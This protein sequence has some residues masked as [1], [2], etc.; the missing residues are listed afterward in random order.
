MR[1]FRLLALLVFAAAALLVSAAAAAT[2]PSTIPLPNGWAPEGIASG[3]GNTLYVGSLKNGAVWAGSA[4][5]GEGKVR[6]QGRSG[7]SATGL[8]AD[9]RE[10]LFVAGALTGQGYV[11]NARTGRD[12]AVYTFTAKNTGFINDVVVTRRAA[13][14]TDSINPRLYVVPIA[15][16]GQLGPKRS[17]PLTGA[18]KYTKG[19]NVNGI[20]ATPDGKTLFLVQTNTGRLFTAD[21]ATGVTRE[22]D[23]G[24]ETLKNGDG[25]VFDDR[26]LWVALNRSNRVAVVRLAANLR[27]GQVGEP[28]TNPDFDVPSTLAAV[29]D[30]LYAVNARF[31]TPPRKTTKYDIVRVGE[32]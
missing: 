6:V 7:R 17:L 22:I 19:F 30:R 29:G 3:S 25:M 31:N 21:A 2:F 1:R 14:F 16:D 11:Y 5:S 28:L 18:L 12:I 10:R 26:T 9:S 24:G 27:S 4:R 23:L 32:D 13:Y 8:K 15:G 20:E